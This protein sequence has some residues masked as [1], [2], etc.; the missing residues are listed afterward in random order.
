M[1]KSRTRQ[2]IK[3]VEGN[4]YKKTSVSSTKLKQKN[5]D[6]SKYIEYL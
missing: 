3:G 4:I 2:K 1:I 5:K 6:G